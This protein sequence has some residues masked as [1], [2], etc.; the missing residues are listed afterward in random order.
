MKPLNRAERNNAF[1]RFLL[2]FCI[3]IALIITV[4]FFSIEVPLKESAKLR[5][6]MFSMRTEKEL[7][8]SFN[9]VMKEAMVEIGRFEANKQQGV[10]PEAT[11]QN[12]LY[13]I[14]RMNAI[15]LS[16]TNEEN[17]IY[18]LVVQNISDLNEA[19]K[20]LSLK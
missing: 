15:A 3:T 4:L 11:Y 16:I 13:K 9:L 17:S 8:D 18:A 12:V 7:S 5:K 2:L 14:R 6:T 1:L 19:K 20:T 10:S